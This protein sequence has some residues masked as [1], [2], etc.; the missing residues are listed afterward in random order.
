MLF[1]ELVFA[2]VPR[3]D[4]VGGEV[5]AVKCEEQV[6]EPDMLCVFK[7]VKDG[8]KEEFAKVVD[9]VGDE[10]GYAQVVCSSG[11]IFLCQVFDLDTGEVKEGI[12]VVG[13]EF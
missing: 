10:G 8:V 11:A 2:D 6:A 13:S 9:G 5:T 1:Q 3:E 4:V 12:F 7:G